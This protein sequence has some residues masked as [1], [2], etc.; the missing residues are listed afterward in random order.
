MDILT[1]LITAVILLISPVKELPPEKNTI[2]V[3]IPQLIDDS[4]DTDC[5][6]PFPL[7]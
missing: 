5:I 3:C 4:G 6:N 7:G 2:E 1:S